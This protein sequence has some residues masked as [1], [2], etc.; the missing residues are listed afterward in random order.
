MFRWIVQASRAYDMDVAGTAVNTAGRD[1]H[2][3]LVGEWG[4][5]VQDQCQRWRRRRQG[6][7]RRRRDRTNLLS[8]G[9]FVIVQ[10]YINKIFKPLSYLRC[11]FD[12]LVR[13]RTWSDSWKG[14]PMGCL[15]PFVLLLPTGMLKSKGQHSCNWSTSNNLWRRWRSEVT[16][17]SP[18][19][20]KRYPLKI[21][22]QK[23]KLKMYCP[24]CCPLSQGEWVHKLPMEVWWVCCLKKSTISYY[25]VP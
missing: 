3:P 1:M 15:Q 6:W 22:K 19:F 14:G 4:G 9:S 21:L 20:C 17:S 7:R 23:G 12:K 10:L 2:W 8:P 25:S 16:Q 11:S 18:L 24:I 13:W 5:H